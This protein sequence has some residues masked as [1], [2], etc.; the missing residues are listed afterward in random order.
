MKK[1]IEFCTDQEAWQTYNLL[2]ENNVKP[3]LRT[4]PLANRM[5]AL[6]AFDGVSIYV[7]CYSW[8]INPPN[9]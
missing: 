2:K 7:H 8:H 6:A 1:L 5:S 4:D 9:D 3:S